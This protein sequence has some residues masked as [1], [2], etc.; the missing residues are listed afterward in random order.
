MRECPFN[1]GDFVFLQVLVSCF[2]PLFLVEMHGFCY[3]FQFQDFVVFGACEIVFF[4][5]MSRLVSDFQL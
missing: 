4:R 3:R 5:V 1:Y 2:F